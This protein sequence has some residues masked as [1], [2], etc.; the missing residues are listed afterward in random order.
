MQRGI[1]V[2]RSTKLFLKLIEP[3]LKK[4]A[5]H[6]H[7]KMGLD[8]KTCVLHL[9]SLAAENILYKYVIGDVIPPIVWLFHPRTGH[10]MSQI[11]IESR[12]RAARQRTSSGVDVATLPQDIPEDDDGDS[13][14]DDEVVALRRVLEDGR[15]L[16]TTEYRVLKFCL[17]NAREHTKHKESLHQHLA[18]CL[19]ARRNFISRTYGIAY[20][21]IIK[22]AGLH[23]RFL[24]AKGVRTP[25]PSS[26]GSNLAADDVVR[27][28]HML[29]EGASAL[30]VAMMFETTDVTVYNLKRKYY[31]CTDDEIRQLRA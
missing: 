24:S 18:Q 9:G 12:K 3:K 4:L 6:A 13:D 15:T 29:R 5:Y 25:V 20:R 27:V 1:D 2:N 30:D 21:K 22:A 14:F 28:I 31:E 10:I 17:S 26:T 19:E 23:E 7:E 11:E 8:Y 16:T